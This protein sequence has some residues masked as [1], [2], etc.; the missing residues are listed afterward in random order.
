MEIKIIW[1]LH[2]RAKYGGAHTAEENALKGLPR[3]LRGEAARA[4]ER[5]IR[6]RL[7]LVK[8]TGYGRHVSLNRD[9]VAFLHG[10]CDWYEVHHAE[11]QDEDVYPFPEPVDGPGRG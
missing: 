1:K 8:P 6:L 5:L 4:L 10:V 9:A 2:R 3:S 11:V 7:V